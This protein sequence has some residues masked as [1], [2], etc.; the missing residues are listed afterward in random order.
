MYKLKSDADRIKL[1]RVVGFNLSRHINQYNG[2][3]P[4]KILLE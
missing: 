1:I 3:N 2:A 4:V